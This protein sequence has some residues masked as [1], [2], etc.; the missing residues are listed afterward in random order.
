MDLSEYNL[1]YSNS[2]YKNK[3]CCLYDVIWIHLPLIQ[4]TILNH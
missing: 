1:L 4:D 3:I 2:F